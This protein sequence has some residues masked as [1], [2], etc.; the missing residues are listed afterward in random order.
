MFLVL[1]ICRRDDEYK[2]DKCS[3]ILTDTKDKAFKLIIDL[4]NKRAKERDNIDKIN[5]TD[6]LNLKKYSMNKGIWIWE[7]RRRGN[8]DFYKIV[9]QT[10]RV[11]LQMFEF[12]YNTE[13][14]ITILGD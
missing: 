2:Y 13:D 6:E 11:K 10:K 8:G 1:H 4:I 3:S 5:D 7:W 12:N 14:S 9:E